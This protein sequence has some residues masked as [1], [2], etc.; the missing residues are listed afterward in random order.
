MKQAKLDPYLNSLD[1]QE[2]QAYH[3]KKLTEI[4]VYLLDE[5]EVCERQA[6]NIKY[7][8]R[9]TRTVDISLKTW[10]VIIGRVSIVAFASG[11]FAFGMPVETV[12]SKNSKLFFLSTVIT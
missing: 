1:P 12:L 9:T 11:A 6:K 2:V 7:H 4:E 3:L 8:N 5:I 10:I